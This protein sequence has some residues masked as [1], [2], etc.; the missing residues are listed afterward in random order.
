MNRHMRTALLILT[1][2]CLVASG[3]GLVL[4]LHLPDH[5]DDH[6]HEGR[7]HA[8]HDSEHCPICQVMLVRF[9]KYVVEPQ[10]AIVRVDGLSTA[11]PEDGATFTQHHIP[12]VLAPR[13]PPPATA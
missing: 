11:A 7:G 10:I 12:S 8:R 3:S 6:G 13:P 1:T 2:A 9:A 5:P 4:W